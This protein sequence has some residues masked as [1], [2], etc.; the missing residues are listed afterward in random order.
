MLILPIPAGYKDVVQQANQHAAAQAIAS[1]LAPV[2]AGVALLWWKLQRIGMSMAEFRRA[3]KP[4]APS[5]YIPAPIRV[6]FVQVAPA[7]EPASYRDDTGTQV[8]EA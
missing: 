7:V 1:L 6:E 4:E 8:A 2:V 5:V 3:M